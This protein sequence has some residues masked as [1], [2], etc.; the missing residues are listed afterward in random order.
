MRRFRLLS[1]VLTDVKESEKAPAELAMAL[2]TLTLELSAIAVY[3]P[4]VL[5]QVVLQAVADLGPGTG[6]VQD[7]I[8]LQ[9]LLPCLWR[10]H[11]EVVAASALFTG[12]VSTLRGRLMQCLEI[13]LQRINRVQTIRAQPL[14]L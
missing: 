8:G 11:T 6:L 1:G 10:A 3:R 7:Q 14:C 12:E 4:A 9:E 2:E 5:V 13:V